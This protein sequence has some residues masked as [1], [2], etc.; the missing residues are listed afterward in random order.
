MLVVGLR[1]TS[2]GTP[3]VVQVDIALTPVTNA[4]DKRAAKDIGQGARCGLG[5]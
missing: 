5:S 2:T 3:L 1:L 4:R